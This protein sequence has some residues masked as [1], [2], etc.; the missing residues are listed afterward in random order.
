VFFQLYDLLKP[1][2]WPAGYQY[3]AG[4]ISGHFSSPAI[5]LIFKRRIALR[6][7]GAEREWHCGRWKCASP[8][9]KMQSAVW[10]GFTADHLSI[11]LSHL[12]RSEHFNPSSSSIQPGIIH[13]RTV[14]W[15]R[16]LAAHAVDQ[17]AAVCGFAHDSNLLF[18]GYAEPDKAIKQG[19]SDCGVEP[20]LG[21]FYVVFSF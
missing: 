14:R 8:S 16:Y 4:I 19:L 15:Q 1:F 18:Q 7:T 11:F 5:L 21:A 3:P 9:G 10:R 6:P 13:L 20:D 12:G 17:L 2:T